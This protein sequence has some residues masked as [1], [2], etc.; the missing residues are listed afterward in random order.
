MNVEAKS[1]TLV[2]YSGYDGFLE[3]DPS[4]GVKLNGYEVSFPVYNVTAYL[5]PETGGF[6]TTAYTIGG[7]TLMIGAAV[8][9][10]YNYSK[11]RREDQLPS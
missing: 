11:R 6:G 5:L 3:I 2:R 7:L 1:I 4:G 9:L 10:L 8:I